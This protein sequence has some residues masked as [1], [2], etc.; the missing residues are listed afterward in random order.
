M[1][2]AVNASQMTGRSSNGNLQGICH[3]NLLLFL[4]AFD[5]SLT[6]LIGSRARRRGGHFV[7]FR[8]TAAGRFRSPFEGR[9]GF[10]WHRGDAG[11]TPTRRF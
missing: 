10:G 2:E 1:Q 3:S 4:C 11:A 9:G 5:A 6:I 7:L 8:A